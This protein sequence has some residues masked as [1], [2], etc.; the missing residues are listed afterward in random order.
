MYPSVE[1]LHPIDV[2]RLTL[3]KAD[4]I[5]DLCAMLVE[6]IKVSFAELIIDEDTLFLS[7]ISL[8]PRIIVLLSHAKD[9]DLRNP[10]RFKLCDAVDPVTLAKEINKE[11]LASLGEVRLS[12]TREQVLEVVPLAALAPDVLESLNPL[13]EWNQ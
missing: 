10:I 7:I 8:D 6:P 2:G 9:K 12:V 11:I 13:F 3:A 1:I 5:S 4:R